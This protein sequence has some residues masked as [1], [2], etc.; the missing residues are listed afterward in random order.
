MCRVATR[1]IV[2]LLVSHRASGQVRLLAADAIDSLPADLL[3]DLPG[4]AAQA[5]AMRL[6]LDVAVALGDTEKERAAADVR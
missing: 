3:T 4:L 5:A 1:A 6:S 2:S